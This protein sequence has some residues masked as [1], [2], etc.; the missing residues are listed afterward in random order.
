MRCLTPFLML[1]TIVLVALTAFNTWQISQLREE[2]AGVKQKTHKSAEQ[3]S[4]ERELTKM[5]ADAKQQ[6]EHARELISG[7]QVARA[8]LELN[9]SIQKIEKATQ[10]SKDMANG[11][12]RSVTGVVSSLKSAISGASKGKNQERPGEENPTSRD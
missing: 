11:A 10:L 7:G 5:L 4:A 12:A 2:L 1:V 8:R 3:V 9:R 6:T